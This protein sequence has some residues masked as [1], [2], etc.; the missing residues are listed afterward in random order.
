MDKCLVCDEVNCLTY[1]LEEPK[2]FT[3]NKCEA[4]YTEEEFSDKSCFSE[5]HA[6]PSFLERV[7]VRIT[8][9]YISKLIAREYLKYLRL[10][11]KM[12]FK[13]SLDI[14]ASYGTFVNELNKF[15]IDSHGIESDQKIV[16]LAVTKKIKWQ[17]F[18]KNYNSNIKYDLICLNQM[19]SFMRDNYAVLK[20]VKNMLTPNGV[21]FIVDPNPKSPFVK[22]GLPH[23]LPYANMI[24]SKKNFESLQ[25][26]V[27]LELI[28][29]SVYRSNLAIDFR[30]GANKKYSFLKYFLKLKKAFEL[31]PEGNLQFVLLKPSKLNI[32]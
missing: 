8:H 7:W 32:S 4:V 10:K 24:L 20:C 11:T 15:G 18:D 19:I 17:H 16:K 6:N 25:N 22:E 27:G 31:D 5:E 12:D 1:Y 30:R 13:N 2:I 23:R 14:G 26:K 9:H 3:C 21:I 29:Y 28:D